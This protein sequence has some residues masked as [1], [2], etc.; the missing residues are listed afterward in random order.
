MDKFKAM[1]AFVLAAET[2]GYVAAGLKLGVTPQMV[3]KHIKSLER[4]LNIRL[5]HRTTRRQSLTVLG[6]RYYERCKYILSEAQSADLMVKDALNEPSGKIRITAPVNFSHP[7]FMNFFNKFLLQYPGVEIELYLTDQL[8]N[9]S[10]DG[11][12]IAFRYGGDLIEAGTVTRRKLKQYKM[13]A[14]A[15]PG[16]LS[17]HG[18]PLHPADLINHKC[19]TYL[20]NN[21]MP[22][23]KWTFTDNNESFHICV[24]SSLYVNDSRALISAGK[25]GAGVILAPE[26]LVSE[27][28]KKSELIPVLSHYKSHSSILNL[29]YQADRQ[30]PPLLKHFIECAV[31]Y[32][33]S[34]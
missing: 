26:D 9:L 7:Y 2:G 23:S 33:S 31:T 24:N 16:Y 3:A 25:N 17:K 32:F 27:A 11:F 6:Q 10:R 1:Q 5:F 28:F 4:H 19:L 8:T 12:D 22:V 30:Q 13:I 34:E 15:S 18:T 14:C 20:D 29:I 21:R